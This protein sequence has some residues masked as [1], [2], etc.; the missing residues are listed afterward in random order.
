[1]NSRLNHSLDSAGKLGQE[2]PCIA[3]PEPNL[4]LQQD[5]EWC[6]IQDGDEW[7]QIRFHDYG[8]LY[9]IPG[10]YE[11]LF[12]DILKCNSPTMVR[13]L[14]EEQ[15]VKTG[16]DA[17]E[18]RFLDVGAGNGMVGEEL[19]DLGVNNVVGID[20]IEEAL[21]AGERDRP[22]VY[23][24]YLVADLTSLSEEE[25]RRLDNCDFN[26]L[27]CVAALGFGDIPTAAFQTAYNLIATDGWIAFNI[28]EDF[29]T[30]QDPSGFS[31]L[32][33]RM[34][35]EG[36]LAVCT[37]KRYQHRIATNGDPLFYVA[38]VG[39]KRGDIPSEWV[40]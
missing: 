6:V 3:L 38:I 13:K 20:I 23:E 25:K 26:G 29:L 24:D 39:R 34:I 28:K 2:I 31:S 27:T 32:I 22:S 1:M 19:M 10:L 8:E 30:D 18:L 5:T 17:S 14:L 33:R 40:E 37:Q 21:L 4:S 15:L 35:E 16:Q 9:T 36:L 7:R 11:R 12:Y